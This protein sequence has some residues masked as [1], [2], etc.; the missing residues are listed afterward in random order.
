MGLSM[1]MALVVVSASLVCSLKIQHFLNSDYLIQYCRGSMNR[2]GGLDY[3]DAREVFGCV[4]VPV[5]LISTI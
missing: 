5:Y 1:L 4:C 3:Q 2:K